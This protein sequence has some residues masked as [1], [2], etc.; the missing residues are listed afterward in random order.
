MA[1]IKKEVGKSILYVKT[2]GAAVEYTNDIDE[3]FDYKPRGAKIQATKL[4]SA[5]GVKHEAVE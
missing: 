2:G 4:T 3:A 5:T 1:V